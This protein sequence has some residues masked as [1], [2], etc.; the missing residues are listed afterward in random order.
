MLCGTPEA[1]ERRCPMS[2]ALVLPFVWA[3]A[4]PDVA[5]PPSPP[6]PEM[7]FYRKHTEALLRRYVRMSMESGKVPSLLGKEMFRARITSYRVESFED[8]VIFLH[9]VEHC[10]EKLEPADQTLVSRITLQEYTVEETAAFL[11]LNPRT[12]IRHYRRAL[13]RLTVLLLRADILKF[14]G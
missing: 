6:Q 1:E 3:V 4:K 5:E 13:D 14:H 7:A 11:K 2:A 12:V 9:D 8:I 10:I